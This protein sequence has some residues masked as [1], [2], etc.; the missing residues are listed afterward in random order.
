MWIYNLFTNGKKYEK[1]KNLATGK[2]L[3][4]KSK[5]NVR[6]GG[7]HYVPDGNKK[8]ILSNLYW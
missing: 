8:Q 4:S 7:R 2:V 1:L 3:V 6:I 5:Y